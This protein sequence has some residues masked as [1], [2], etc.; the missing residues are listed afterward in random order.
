[1]LM[2]HY[3]TTHLVMA[4]TPAPAPGRPREQRVDDAVRVAVLSLLAE[5]GYQRTTIA[6]VA[7]RAGV[8]RGALYRR[9]RSKGEM[10]F[11]AVVHGL[12]LR[13]PP[14][15]GSLTGDLE[16]LGE[17][18]ALLSDSE[19][20]HAAML[21]LTAELDTHAGLREALD[22][23]LWAVERRYLAVIL[24]RA[25]DQGE[26]RPGIDPELVRRLL[27]GAIAIAP[28]YG[29]GPTAGREAAAIV[30]AGL[31]ARYPP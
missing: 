2:V 25:V 28:I 5:R 12:D 17:R 30:A 29:G 1:M 24:Q 31:L 23:R 19:I 11:G 6:A 18:I 14:R 9:W 13:D 3:D 26:I 15:H 10:V 8:G 21:G 27:V 22:A 7:E 20:A 4:E 16:A